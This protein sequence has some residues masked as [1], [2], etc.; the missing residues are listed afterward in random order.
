MPEQIT[1]VENSSSF[2]G[3]VLVCVCVCKVGRRIHMFG[4]ATIQPLQAFY[5]RQ[6]RGALMRT[7]RPKHASDHR[8]S[9]IVGGEGDTRP[10]QSTG[11]EP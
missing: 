7:V 9:S 3:F 6:V 1:Q 5:F 4:P 8:Q 2:N 10:Q 11:A